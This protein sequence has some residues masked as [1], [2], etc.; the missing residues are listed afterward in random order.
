MDSP[1]EGYWEDN[2]FEFHDINVEYSIF[3]PKNEFERTV[4]KE[5]PKHIAKFKTD[6]N[7]LAIFCYYHEVMST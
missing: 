5:I 2:G 6:F 7:Q 4:K 1:S 3:I